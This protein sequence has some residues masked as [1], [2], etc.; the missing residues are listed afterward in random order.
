MKFKLLKL[1]LLTEMKIFEDLSL[2]K[3]KILRAVDSSSKQI[4]KESG[5]TNTTKD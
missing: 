1:G 2:L 4:R 3:L 5:D